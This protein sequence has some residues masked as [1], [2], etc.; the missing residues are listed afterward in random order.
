M[1]HPILRINSLAKRR[2]PHILLFH[3]LLL[4]IIVLLNYLIIVINLLLHLRI[5]LLQQHQLLQQQLSIVFL[6]LKLSL[7]LSVLIHKRSVLILN[8]LCDI[9]DQL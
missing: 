2:Q 1:I 4:F 6:R 8:P 7:Q 3:Y 9:R 5:L